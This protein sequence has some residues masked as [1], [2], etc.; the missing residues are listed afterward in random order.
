MALLK[1]TCQH[2]GHTWTPRVMHRP[3]RCPKC[4][5]TAWDKPREPKREALT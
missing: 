5:N 4:F 3:V 2:C 1:H